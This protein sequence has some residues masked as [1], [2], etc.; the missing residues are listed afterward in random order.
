MCAGSGVTCYIVLA[1]PTIF[2]TGLDHDTT[3]R[4]SHPSHSSAMLRGILRLNVTKSAKIKAVT[5]KFTGRAR[6]EWPE[7]IPPAKIETFEEESLRT[8]VLPF[9]NALYEGSETGYGT[10]C[11][12]VLRQKS[13]SS[14]VVNLAGN[15]SSTSLHSPTTPTGSGGV[16]LANINGRSSRSSSIL[17]SKELKRLSL[18]NNQ[19][20]SFQKGE[21]PYGPTPQQKGYKTFH[22]G[23]YEYSFELPLDNTNP[24]TTNLP[25]ASVKWMLEV[26]VERSGTFKPN[27]QG[28]KEVP[29]VRSPSEDSLELVEP[30]SISRK[31]EDQL[32]YEIII[33]GKSF[34][35]GSRIPIAFKLTPL[36][37]VRVHK[38]KVYVTENMEYF[39]SNKRVA[40]RETARKILLL[41]KVAGKPLPKEFETSEVRV[42]AGGEMSAEDRARAR[43][44]TMRYRERIASIHGTSAEPLPEPTENMLGELDLGEQYWGQ[45]EIE[46]NVQL[47][48]CEM[49]DKDKTKRLAHDCTWKNVNVHHWIK[50]VMRISRVDHD[51][52]EG[53]KRRHFEISIDSPFTILNC[54]ATRDNLMLPQYSNLNATSAGQQ[55]VCGCPNAAATAT[56]RAESSPSDEARE[57]PDVPETFVPPHLTRP[58]L[59]HLSGGGPQRPMHMLRQPSFNPPAFDDDT[60]PP[61]LPTPPPLYDLVIGTPSHDGLADYFARLGETYDDDDDDNHTDDEDANRASTRGRVN[62]ANPRTSSGRIARSMDID[63]NFMFSPTASATL[64]RTPT[65][66]S[67]PDTPP[68][69]T[70]IEP[71]PVEAT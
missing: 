1:E 50:I 22:P 37:K 19:S 23:V 31:W 59:A 44:T 62:V 67:Q 9:F 68:I 35:L 4:E 30:I 34:P 61:P 2:L 49:M 40:R 39:T 3:A 28:F 20:R 63:R 52:P 55:H 42:L 56:M 43:E 10:L 57:M 51:D 29:V 47:P 11:N 60:P 66:E 5:L 48:T 13:A 70:T 16:T 17:S 33:S 58:P 12:Y 46:M 25:L 38:L 24:E 26:L 32:F 36:A 27:L 14:S 21:S 7:G 64:V 69:E 53:K 18:Q 15:Q 71:A 65:G 6:T 45:T 54:R 41:E 8:Q